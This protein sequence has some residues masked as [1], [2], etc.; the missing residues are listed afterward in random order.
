MELAVHN[1]AYFLK[2][3]FYT[4]RLSISKYTA[5]DHGS[6]LRQDTRN[7]MQSIANTTVYFYLAI[8]DETGKVIGAWRCS[9]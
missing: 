3:H 7:E 8:I 5:H 1:A 2:T 4:T 9:I 6:A